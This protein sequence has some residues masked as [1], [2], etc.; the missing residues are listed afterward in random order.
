M[1]TPET[2]QRLPGYDEEALL[3]PYPRP[4]V[5]VGHCPDCGAPIFGGGV[6]DPITYKCECRI[7]QT[8]P[9]LPPESPG[10]PWTTPP[11][12]WHPSYGPTYI[13]DYP[14]WTVTC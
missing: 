9:S 14:R 11:P 4:P 13:G 10:F 12:Y 3:K 6:N 5:I 7:F 2:L 8:P 1:I